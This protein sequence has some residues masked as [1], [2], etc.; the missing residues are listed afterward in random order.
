[1]RTANRLLD[2]VNSRAKPSKS[3]NWHFASA[4]KLSILMRYG[5]D[6]TM[7]FAAKQAAA[8]LS[9]SC[10]EGFS[11]MTFLAT[12]GVGKGDSDRNNAAITEHDYRIVNKTSYVSCYDN[13]KKPSRL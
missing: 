6:K 9:R 12:C 3:L 4:S 2:A 8:L 5:G 10:T 13:G 1:M 7:S 11:I